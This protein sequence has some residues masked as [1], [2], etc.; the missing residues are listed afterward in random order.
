[1]TA[2][3]PGRSAAIARIFASTLR[4]KRT[5]LLAFALG[6]AF[7]HALIAVSF[8]A[9]GGLAA[10]NS[11][12]QTFP[13]GLRTL[14]RIA[15][16]LQAGFG[17]RDYLA[18]SWFHPVFLGLGA[19]FV[20]N[21]AADALAQGIER[22]TVYLTLSRPIRRSDLVLGKAGELLLSAGVITLA[23]WVGLALGAAFTLDV[24]LPMGRYLLAAGM[25]WLL[26]AA[27]G[28]GALFISACS[29]RGGTAA[30][31]GSA[32]TLIAF[33]LDVIPAVADSPLG[34]LNPWHT[35]YP[36]EIVATGRVDPL[37]VVVLLAWIV[38]GVTA[39]VWAFGLRDL[40]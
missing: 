28:S 10:V 17:V 16:N 9:I 37:G 34:L 7:F 6:M 33:A 22:G 32:W 40:N 25:A 15:P 27:L 30:G 12:V 29:S 8:P 31:W 38:G 24:P 36:Q 4:S 11:V 23:G 14:L 3:S 19:A 2:D 35:Y 13:D 26:F 5:S 18:L 39:A 21:R 20:V 1:M